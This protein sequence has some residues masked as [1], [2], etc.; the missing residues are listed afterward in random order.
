MIIIIKAEQKQDNQWNS[1]MANW[2]Q[3]GG[4]TAIKNI[5]WK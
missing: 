3:L 4:E 1:I 2:F 5:L